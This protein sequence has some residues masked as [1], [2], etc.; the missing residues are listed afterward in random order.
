MQ[1]QSKCTDDKMTIYAKSRDDV[2]NVNKT[3]GHKKCGVRTGYQQLRS[4]CKT[5]W[6]FYILW[7]SGEISFKFYV[8]LGNIFS[9][10]HTTYHFDMQCCLDVTD[11]VTTLKQ[12][13]VVAGFSPWLLLL[14]KSTR[15]VSQNSASFT[16]FLY[17]GCP[18]VSFPVSL[19]PQMNNMCIF[20]VLRI[21]HRWSLYL[22]SL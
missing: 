22:I 13:R 20:G 11:V 15:V 21:R 8:K 7:S 12:R 10:K 19:L 3:R 6:H 2:L 5:F 9:S 17:T 18:I 14:F 16:L 1:C 4:K